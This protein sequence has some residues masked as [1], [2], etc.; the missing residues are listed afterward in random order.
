M[1]FDKI[2]LGSRSPRRKELL[3]LLI[4]P[5]AICVLPPRSSEE[6]GFDE[7][8]D[9]ESISAQLL[10][11]C[12][13]KNNDVFAQVKST[14]GSGDPILTAD[15]IVVVKGEQTGHRVLGQPPAGPGWEETVRG[16]FLDEYAGKTHQVLT[17]LCFRTGDQI[18]TEIAQTL[19]TFHDIDFVK[20]HLDWY[21][22]SQES[23]GKAGGYA[24]QGA[25]SLFVQ[26][27][28]GSLSNVVGLPLELVIRLLD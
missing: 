10:S 8:S 27:I 4:P 17:G 19:V 3:S 26:R 12:T 24:V 15:T 9:L 1:R 11:I 5:S 2:I 28:E 21:L 16:W 23:I 20:R 22:S 6:A 18:I 13:T 14:S 7:F 25:G